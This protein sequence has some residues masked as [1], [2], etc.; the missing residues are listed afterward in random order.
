MFKRSSNLAKILFLRPNLIRNSRTITNLCSPGNRRPRLLLDLKLNHK[1]HEEFHRTSTNLAQDA[2]KKYGEQ[3]KLYF[4]PSNLLPE[5]SDPK[6]LRKFKEIPVICVLGWTGS[7]DKEIQKYSSI[8]NSMGYHTVRFSPSNSLV[9]FE[10]GK[11]KRYT[12][13]FLDFL[14]NNNLSEN[15]FFLH[16]FSNASFF[17]FYHHLVDIHNSK[18]VPAGSKTLK[19]L[20]FF[21][22]NQTGVIFDSG[23][24]LTV[25]YVKLIPGIADLVGKKSVLG[26]VAGITLTAIYAILFAIFRE[27][28]YFSKGFKN[29]IE[30]DARQIPTLHIYSR[31]DKLI[32][33]K[34]ISAFCDEKKKLY[35]N[36]YFKSVVYDDAEHVKIYMQYP[37]EYL[38][39]IKEHLKVSNTEID[40]HIQ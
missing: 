39:L 24:G 38:Q 25:D 30:N 18:Y 21:T 9:F 13:E 11:H 5:K 15:K 10:T 22:K 17:L 20:D 40:K 16:T 36:M 8:Y 7:N 14:R 3:N 31:A 27:N 6:Y 19:E 26:Y 35:P 29:Y 1:K 12:E 33:A 4:E 23:I 28:N 37:E 32:C 2:S 34:K